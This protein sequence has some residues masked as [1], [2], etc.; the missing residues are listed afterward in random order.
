[1]PPFL[2]V[3]DG[4]SARD[5]R[6]RL[7]D[8]FNQLTGDI[9][10]AAKSLQRDCELVLQNREAL[11]S[12]AASSMQLHSMVG[13]RMNNLVTEHF[14]LLERFESHDVIVDAVLRAVLDDTRVC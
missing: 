9:E 2:L 4:D 5:T 8:T 7:Q 1:M 6:M 12:M 3:D 11:Q 10:E 14:G 13:E